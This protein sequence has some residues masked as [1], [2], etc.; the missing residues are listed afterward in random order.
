MKIYQKE[1]D[2]EAIR[3]RYRD[4]ADPKY[5]VF[6]EWRFRESGVPRNKIQDEVAFSCI[7]HRAE[8]LLRH[9]GSA[10]RLYPGHA[11]IPADLVID[12]DADEPGQVRDYVDESD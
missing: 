5:R 3:F 11:I 1:S 9:P 4:G 2:R 12:V 8:F 6:P 7:R 10:I